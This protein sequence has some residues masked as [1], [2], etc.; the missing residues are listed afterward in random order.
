MHKSANEIV[1]ATESVTHLIR[2]KRL[3]DLCGLVEVVYY[4]LLGDVILVAVGLKGADTGAMLVPLMLPQSR[5]VA[6]EIFPVLAD[7]L[8]QV[9]TTR[10]DQDQR[11]IAVLATGVA[12]LVKPAVAVIGP[13]AH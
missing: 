13:V 3:E 7:V 5:V 4:F 1:T 6:P 12:E 11:D 9:P 8:E 2:R 10:V